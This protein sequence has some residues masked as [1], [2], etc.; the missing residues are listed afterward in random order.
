MIDGVAA[1]GGPKAASVAQDSRQTHALWFDGV[2]R[3]VLLV[4]APEVLAGMDR[5]THG[6]P[7]GRLAPAATNAVDP[8][9]RV[10]RTAQG[11]DVQSAFI[12]APF[13]DLPLASTVCAVLADIAEARTEAWPAATVI[14]AAAVEIEGQV[15]A[16]IGPSR[17]GKSTLAARLGAEPDLTLYCDDMLPV[18]PDGTAVALGIAPRIRL[19]LP[20]ALSEEFRA[21]IRA[22]TALADESYAFLTTPNLAPHG[23]RA[24][25]AALVWLDRCTSGAVR[26]LNVPPSEAFARLGDARMQIGEGQGVIPGP[27]LSVIAD[28][29]C[30]ELSYTDLEEAVS[31][32]R[33]LFD[34]AGADLSTLAET[35]QAS[36][37]SAC[38]PVAPC[39]V[40]KRD[41]L[42]AARPAPSG[43]WLT[44]RNSAAIVH[45]NQVGAAVWQLLGLPASAAMI[46]QDLAE[47]FPEVGAARIAEDVARL[48]GQMLQAGLVHPSDGKI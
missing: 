35:R 23:T 42:A 10:V 14:H 33:A 13:T 20:T 28:L 5:V 29:P 12:P 32:I 45:L 39:L 18:L 36:A 7:H 46:A 24:P 43:L 27:L 4:D 11:Y 1:S 2:P 47:V 40:L 31:A 15:V 6:W 34:N 41:R 22:S 9:C 38:L 8:A 44:R 17:A 37:P 3:P 21:H 30:L 19:P 16:F 26:F 25:L 48:L